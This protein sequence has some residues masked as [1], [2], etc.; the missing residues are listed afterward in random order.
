MTMNEYLKQQA[1]ELQE[2]CEAGT[3][4]GFHSY[5]GFLAQFTQGLPK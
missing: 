1:E 2:K 3:M 5:L 4:N